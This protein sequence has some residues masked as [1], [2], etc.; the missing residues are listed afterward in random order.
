MLLFGYIPVYH[1]WHLHLLR[2][3]W[4]NDICVQRIFRFV[5]YL[6]IMSNRKFVRVARKLPCT[7]YPDSPIVNVLP[8]LSFVLFLYMCMHYYFYEPLQFM[9][10]ELVKLILPLQPQPELC[11][12]IHLFPL[13]SSVS[14]LKL[15][16]LSLLFWVPP[17]LCW[18]NFAFWM[19]RASRSQRQT[20]RYIQRRFILPL[21]LSS[22]SPPALNG[23]SFIFF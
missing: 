3:W 20:E 13:V 8:P 4:K 10:C 17:H 12:W 2:G 14:F 15:L 22:Q 9:V 11:S 1:L 5:F 18:F 19:C 21:C 16:P 7:L 6:E 23:T